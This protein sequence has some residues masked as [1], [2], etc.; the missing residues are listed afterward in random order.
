[1]SKK[2]RTFARTRYLIDRRRIPLARDAFAI[3]MQRYHNQRDPEMEPLDYYGSS[4]GGVHQN[5]SYQ[6]TH[7]GGYHDQFTSTPTRGGNQLGPGSHPD[8][9]FNRQNRQPQAPPP[10]QDRAYAPDYYQQPPQQEQLYQ[11]QFEQPQQ[12][13]SPRD[14]YEHPS[15]RR[16]ADPRYQQPP[17]YGPNPPNNITPGADNFSDAASGGMAGIAYTVAER[18]PRE[19]GMEAIRGEGPYGRGG[20]GSGRGPYHNDPNFPPPAHHPQG[21]LG[22]KGP[23]ENSR[24][25]SPNENP[26]AGGSSHSGSSHSSIAPVGAAAAVPGGRRS[27]PRGQQYGGAGYGP[28]TYMDDP[29]QGYMSQ[30]YASRADPRMAIFNPNDIADDGDEGLEY[31]KPARTSMLSLHSN[32]SGRSGRNGQGAETAAAVAAVGAVGAAGAVGGMAGRRRNSNGVQYDAVHN[33]TSSAAP[34]ESSS[35]FADEKSDWLAKQSGSRK[36]WKWCIGI[37]VALVIIGAVVGGVIGGLVMKKGGKGLSAED[38]E[39]ANGDLGINSKDIKSLLNNKDLHKVFPGMD[40]TPINTQYP[41][42]IGFPPSQNNVT[43]DIAVL[44]Q[45]TNT[46]RLYGTDCNQTEM[47]VHAIQRL[48]M[49][50]TMKVWIGVW[51]DGNTTTNARQLAQLWDIVDQYGAD[52]FAGVIVANEI[53]FRQ[54]MT[55]TQL[56][57]LLDEVR[58]NLT[59]KGIDLPVA[60][61]DLGDALNAEVADK[62]DYIMANIHPFFAGVSADDAAEFTYAFWENNNKPLWKSDTSKNVIAE[63]GWPSQGGTNCGP[64]ATAGS[65]CAAGS[66]AGIPGMQRLMDDWVCQALANGTNYFWFSAFDEPWKERFNTP[67]KAWEDQWGLMDVNRHLKDDLKIPDCG[68][69]TI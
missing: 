31:R 25:P 18:V 58:T 59:G 55:T 50:D 61:S 32:R 54:Q 45:L 30:G 16:D 27:P 28:E 3:N 64:S 69:Q 10:V 12:G 7:G 60:T 48:E 6:Q 20:E 47:V 53:L 43:R 9:Q 38:D 66:V 37:S 41:E 8:S 13:Y 68:G 51:Q 67:G 26:F 29:Y 35:R 62:S 19:S 44:S 4:G 40:Y 2:E 34:A 23:Y 56:A 63:V 42:C 17:T 11:Q 5:N 14:D 52:P 65:D 21:G 15:S 39:A 1:M 22:Q 36:R 49:Q 33:G 46:I 24:Q 57:S